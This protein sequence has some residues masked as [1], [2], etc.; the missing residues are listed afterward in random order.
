V[1]QLKAEVCEAAQVVV[2]Q[3]RAMDGCSIRVQLRVLVLAD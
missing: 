3:Y 2:A 1:Q